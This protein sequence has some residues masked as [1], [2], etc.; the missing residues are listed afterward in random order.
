MGNITIVYWQ[1]RLPKIHHISFAFVSNPLDCKL[2]H[3]LQVSC[4]PLPHSLVDSRDCIDPS[5]RQFGLYVYIYIYMY[6]YLEIAF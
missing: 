5:F 1:L 2:G 6:M 3:C 4:L